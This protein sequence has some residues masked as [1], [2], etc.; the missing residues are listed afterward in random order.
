MEFR[1]GTELRRR[2]DVAFDSAG[3]RRDIAFELGQLTEMVEFAAAG[4][5]TAIVPR[6]FT[7]ELAAPVRNS[8]HILRLADPSL[9]L[10]VCAY[11]C[12]TFR[13]PAAGALTDRIVAARGG[14]LNTAGRGEDAAPH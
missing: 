7:T 2:L 4:L 9:T 10:T 8:V 6:S 14:T 11:T 5:G 1:G 12:P 13:P 3:L